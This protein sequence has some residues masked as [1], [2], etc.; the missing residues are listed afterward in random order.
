VKYFAYGSNMLE[1]RLT[2][3]SRVPSAICIGVG[4]LLGFKIHF[5]KIGM[6][7]S[8]KCNAFAT[9]NKNDSVY[10]VV[11]DIAEKDV[12]V[13][14]E[15]EDI[16]R[17]GYSRR[18]V[19]VIMQKDS[20]QYV[21]NCYFANSE[22]IDNTLHPFDWYKALV[23]A[24]ARD[25]DLPDDYISLLEAYPSIKDRDHFR[26]M[27]A[28]DILGPLYEQYTGNRLTRGSSGRS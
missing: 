3:P 22:F 23:I 12:A 9:G 27:K 24:G 11:F 2:H 20:N 14:D 13:L 17:G 21:V 26:V 18:K 10:G 5:H 7:G 1:A 6:D 19:N 16:E 15:K 28:K 8:A 4:V 25:H